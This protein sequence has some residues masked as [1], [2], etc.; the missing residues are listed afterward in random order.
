MSNQIYPLGLLLSKAFLFLI[1]TDVKLDE[2]KDCYRKPAFGSGKGDLKINSATDVCS[3]KILLT[4][5]H[6][7]T[8]VFVRKIQTHIL[9]L[10]V[11]YHV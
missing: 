10:K 2:I 5:I 9:K 6:T 7:E 3:S 4:V 11:L 8:F 1:F